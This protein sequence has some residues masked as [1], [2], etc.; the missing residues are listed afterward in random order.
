M[1]RLS[2][3]IRRLAGDSRSAS[4]DS[5][6]EDVPGAPT[7]P[8]QAPESGQPAPP[9]MG[10]NWATVS[11][12]LGIDLEV[13]EHDGIIVLA[14]EYFPESGFFIDPMTLEGQHVDVGDIALRHGYFLGN[15]T[16]RDFAAWFP[17]APARSDRSGL[18]VIRRSRG[19]IIGL[20]PDRRAAERARTT[21]M[22]GALG[23]GIRLEESALGSELTVLRPESAGAVATVIASHGGALISLAGEPVAAAPSRGA[24]TTAP[25][26]PAPEGDSWRPGP[27]STADSEARSLQ[28]GGSEEIPRL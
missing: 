17:L 7:W 12:S 23:A 11:D 14:G 20:F 25:S 8:I 2:R 10:L 27:G 4:V 19:S 16:T 6:I 24:P 21:V 5:G 3:A 26:L 28:R 18:P 9:P 1:E 22:Q 15:I 13:L